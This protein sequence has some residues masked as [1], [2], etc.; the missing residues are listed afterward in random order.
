VVVDLLD[1]SPSVSSKSSRFGKVNASEGSRQSCDKFE[2]ARLALLRLL[3]RPELLNVGEELL[4]WGS[5]VAILVEQ[6]L[7]STKTKP[8]NGHLC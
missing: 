4:A 6:W 2:L 3:R 5:I 8:I 7:H 1:I